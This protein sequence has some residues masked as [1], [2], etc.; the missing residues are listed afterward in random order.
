MFLDKFTKEEIEVIKTGMG[1][2]IRKINADL[3]LA[4]HSMTKE[5]REASERI[6]DVCQGIIDKIDL[7]N[8]LG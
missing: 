5:E 8:A 2:F 4:A 1:E 7:N 3:W 6:K